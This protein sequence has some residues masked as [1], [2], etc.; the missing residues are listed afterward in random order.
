MPKVKFEC[1]HGDFTIE[2]FEEWAPK[3]YARVMEL[4]EGGFFED[5]YFFR[6][7]TKPRPFIVQFGIHGDPEVSAKWRDAR[8]KDDP[9]T[10]KNVEGTLTFAT[11]GPGTR[12][13]QLFINLADNTFLDGQGFSP[14]GRVVEGM[15]IV[16]AICDQYGESP[17]QG[18]IQR[19]GNEYLEGKFPNL[20]CIKRAVVLED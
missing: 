7:V 14:L 8:I 15:D 18:A 4:V 12:T 20:D 19:Q 16:R 17:D 2:L 10:Q 3:G 9:V 11:A 6:V 13:T 1:S 5:I